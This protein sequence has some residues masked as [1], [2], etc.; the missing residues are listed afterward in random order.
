MKYNVVMNDS[1]EA[2]LSVL[3]PPKKLVGNIDKNFSKHYG[4]N[5]E[6][7]KLW[8]SYQV[9]LSNFGSGFVK[10]PDIEILSP[11]ENVKDTFNTRSRGQR[12][13]EIY[14]NFAPGQLKAQV[15]DIQPVGSSSAGDSIYFFREKNDG[16]WKILI[17]EEDCEEWEIFN[18]DFITF[19]YKLLTKKLT[20][21]LESQIENPPFQYISAPTK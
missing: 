1:L 9:F 20:S 10:G 8:E 4:I 17:L 18:I 13:L 11:L 21:F 15:D 12:L 3:S 19:L 2:L 7:N 14:N 5:T 6:N 16:S